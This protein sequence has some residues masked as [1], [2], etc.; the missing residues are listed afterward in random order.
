MCKVLE[1]RARM[2]RRPS[3]GGPVFRVQ[4]PVS[5]R[6]YSTQHHVQWS[7]SLFFQLLKLRKKPISLEP[8]QPHAQMVTVTWSNESSPP[9]SPRGSPSEFLNTPGLPYSHKHFIQVWLNGKHNN[10]RFCSLWSPLNHEHAVGRCPELQG[11]CRKCQRFISPRQFAQMRKYSVALE[12][13]EQTHT[14]LRLQFHFYRVWWSHSFPLLQCLGVSCFKGV[15][16]QVPTKTYCGFRTSDASFPY[17]LRPYYHCN[18]HLH[19]FC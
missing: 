12:G 17:W 11:N 5:T 4:S 10:W 16:F 9:P 15:K 7:C 8:P 19:V 13:R 1:P 18:T 3:L 6:C 2:L 14:A